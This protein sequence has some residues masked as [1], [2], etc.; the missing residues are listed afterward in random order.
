MDWADFHWAQDKEKLLQ[1]NLSPI[2]A[3][4]SIPHYDELM[5]D[6][7]TRCS[8]TSDDIFMK[9]QVFFATPKKRMSDLLIYTLMLYKRY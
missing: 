7:E 6:N 5:P 8:S 2:L 1:K 3:Y 9:F 4:V